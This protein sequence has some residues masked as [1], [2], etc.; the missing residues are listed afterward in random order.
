[1]SYLS[2]DLDKPRLLFIHIPKTAGT[3]VKDWFWK[4]YSDDGYKAF[5]H[6]PISYKEL[7]FTDSY[8]FTIVRNP[9]SRAVSWYQQALSLIL[10]NESEKVFKIKGLN[11]KSWDKG[12]DYFIQNFF[13]R[14]A[15]NPNEDIPISPATNQLDYISIDGKILVDKILRFE[16]I[17]EEFQE[18]EKIT[19]TNFGLGKWKV[20]PSDNLRDWK[21]VYTETSKSLIEEI[22]KKDFNFFDYGFE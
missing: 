19:K 6:A 18:I 5:Q 3:S 2:T 1:M 8:K 9:Y 13:D 11:R 21:K 14:V 12:F 15:A 10:K 20:G 17:D 7:R 22:Y 4:V 16:K